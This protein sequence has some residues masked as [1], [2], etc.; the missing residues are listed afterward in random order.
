M[1][2]V[3]DC[4][5]D[6]LSLSTPAVRL[7]SFSVTRLT[8]NALPANERVRNRCSALALRQSCSFTAFAIRICS[9]LTV[10]CTLVQSMLFQGLNA[11]EDAD[12]QA[13]LTCC[14]PVEALQLFSRSETR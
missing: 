3:L 7:P 6:H 14:P 13:I 8:A 12:A 5:V 2:S 10:R 9:R 11:A 4:G 1:A